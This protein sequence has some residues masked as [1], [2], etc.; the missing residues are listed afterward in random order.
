MTGHTSGYRQ[1]DRH[2]C[3]SM[4]TSKYLDP[5]LDHFGRHV[6]GQRLSDKAPMAEYYD[7]PQLLSIPCR[8]YS[9]FRGKTLHRM[10]V[11]T[12]EQRN[13]AKAG[14]AT[15]A[16]SQK[17]STTTLLGLKDCKAEEVGRVDARVTAKT[18]INGGREKR[19]YCGPAKLCGHDMCDPHR[20]LHN[21]T[22]NSCSLD[23]LH[24]KRYC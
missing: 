23:K 16:K 5:L 10:V 12:L 21:S 18:M 7:P 8:L 15:T 3:Q 17:D 1:Q 22:K 4:D 11:R 2:N 6:L 24:N 9:R 14:F 13:R 19:P 20:A